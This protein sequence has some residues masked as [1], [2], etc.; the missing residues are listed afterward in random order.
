MKTQRGDVK[1]DSF[2]LQPPAE[3]LRLKLAADGAF[4][5][6]LQLLDAGKNAASQQPRSRFH[7]AHMCAL[8]DTFIRA[9]LRVTNR[10]Q[11]QVRQPCSN[12]AHT[13]THTRHIASVFI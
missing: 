4:R 3:A 9:E 8:A 2:I 5:P 12:L 10:K 7:A 13:H 1:R 11:R 6:A